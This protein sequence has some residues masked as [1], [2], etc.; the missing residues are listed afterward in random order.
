M[1][2]KFIPYIQD[3]LISIHENIREL[4]ERKNFADSEEL[5]HI[6]GKLMA[7]REVLAILKISAEEFKIP[8]GEIGL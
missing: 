6:E 2:D 4:N 1:P 3:V 7:Y 5:T 8:T